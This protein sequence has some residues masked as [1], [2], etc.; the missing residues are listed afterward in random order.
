[1]ERLFARRHWGRHAGRLLA[2]AVLLIAAPA[3][4]SA[5]WQLKPFLGANFGGNTTLIDP[6][7]AAGNTHLTVGGN[8]VLLGEI[9]GVEADLGH[10][11]RFFRSDDLHL[12]LTGHVTTLTGNV[13]LA[14]PRRLTQYSL[15]PYFVGGGGIM[16]VY[17]QD[18]L[19]VVPTSRVLRVL[20]L[21]G[22]ATGFVTDRVGVDWQL[23]YFRS[24]WGV[25]EHRGLSFGAEQLSF[26]R[27]TMAVAFRY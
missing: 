14:L 10:T 1:M 19:D 7:L 17:I 20:D 6:D 12:V 24:I 13:V 25:D 3:P 22:G 16:R 11:P 15:R 5:E 8:G 21:G 2:A 4:A 27:A 18:S 9:V 26:W 23:R